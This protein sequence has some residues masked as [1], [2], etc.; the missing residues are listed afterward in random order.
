MNDSMKRK[1]Q[2]K[3]KRTELIFII[4]IIYD[5]QVQKKNKKEEISLR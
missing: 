5:K 2:R 4:H 3:E 1:T